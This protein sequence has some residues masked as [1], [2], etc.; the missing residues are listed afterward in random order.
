MID[1][2]L[3]LVS[4]RALSQLPRS[5]RRLPV[6]DLGEIIPRRPRYRYAED[7]DA[8]AAFYLQLLLESEILLL[9]CPGRNYRTIGITVKSPPVGAIEQLETVRRRCTQQE[10]KLDHN[11][12]R[13]LRDTLA[14]SYL[15]LGEQQN[16]LLIHGREA[17]MFPI[18][19]S[20]STPA[21]K[22]QKAHFAN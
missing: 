18:H 14:M 8:G 22:G 21:W 13:N 5:I 10:V 3:N 2:R 16:C 1:D 15:R 12:E 9:I 4:C 17:C 7:R 20:G 19:G 6:N 11:A